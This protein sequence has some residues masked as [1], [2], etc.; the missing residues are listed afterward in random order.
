M[1]MHF[2]KKKSYR[3]HGTDA[4]IEM[5][6]S[7]LVCRAIELLTN[8]LVLLARHSIKSLLCHTV[9]FFSVIYAII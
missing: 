3:H 1:Q 6:C 4:P 7:F 2:P 8:S 9:P 5:K